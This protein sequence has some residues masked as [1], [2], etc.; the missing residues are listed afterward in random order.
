MALVVDTTTYSLVINSADRI[1]GTTNN[2]TYQ[3]N[4]RDFLPDNYNTYKVAFSFQTV[5]GYYSDGVFSNTG[6]ANT[7][8]TPVAISTTAVIPTGATTIYVNANNY[9]NGGGTMFVSGIGIAANTTINAVNALNF[10]INTPTAGVIP[11]GTQLFFYTSAAIYSAAANAATFSSA[12]VIMQNQ[13]RSFS[14]DTQ[15]KGPSTN[16]G[17]LQRDIQTSGSKSNALSCFY[18]QNPP[19]TM[20]RPNQ[21]LMT[22][23]IMNNYPFVGGIVGY[24]NLVPVYSTVITNQNFLTDTYAGG[25]VLA[26]DMTPYTMI[27]EFIPIASSLNSATRAGI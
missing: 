1:S 15:T 12:R 19:R 11:A 3:I 21:N 9:L 23:N 13:G 18:C 27:L 16:L 17:I 4:W 26:T 14:F 22:I 6:P 25:T 5:G 8:S 10:T 2:A 7:G 24:N 20:A